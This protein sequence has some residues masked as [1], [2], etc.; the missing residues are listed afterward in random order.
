M[1]KLLNRPGRRSAVMK[2][3]CEKVEVR[4]P[5]IF[6]V[7]SSAGS[8]RFA[9]TLGSDAGKTLPLADSIPEPP[10]VPDPT[11][12]SDAVSAV[13]SFAANGEPT[14]ASIGLGG[15]G[16]VGLVQ[17]CF[18]YLHVTLDV[19][20]WGAIVLGTIV[21][22][23]VM[24]P[25]VILSQRNSAQMNNNLP[26]IQLL[27]MKMTQA[28]QTGNQIEAARYAQEMMLFMKEKGLNPL[29]N[30][31]VPLA[32]TPLFI[33]FF[34]GLRGMA[35]CPVES[36]TH[37]GLWWFVDLTVPDQYFLLPVITSATMWATIELGVDGGRLDAQNMQVMRYVLRA[38]PLVMIPFTINFPGAILVY[39]CSSNFISLMQVGFLKIPAVREYFK[40]P[41]LIKHSADALP[42]KKKGFVEGA[43]D[44]WTNMKLSKELAERQRIDEMIFTKAGKGPLQKTYK[45]DPTKLTNI[46]AKSK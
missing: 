8:V 5:R 3:F 40:I 44:S 42:I 24:F 14:F 7:Y 34:M 17:N 12:I 18:E 41:K 16:P 37:G 30:L 33:S 10:P 27:Q 26:E 19:P 22:R 29:K 38:I 31:I 9:S 13:Q 36:M 20:W 6:Y 28:R 32:Q 39:W 21:V 25:L 46:Q 1:F 11:T 15:W 43:K 2:L 35:N 4:T 23:V 45:Y